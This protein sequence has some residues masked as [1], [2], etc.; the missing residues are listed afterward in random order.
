MAHRKL[1]P[2]IART[3]AFC[4][5]VAAHCYLEPNEQFGKIVVTL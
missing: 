2:I 5:I 3:F 4:D 1:H